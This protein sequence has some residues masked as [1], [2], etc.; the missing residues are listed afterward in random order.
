MQCLTLLL[1]SLVQSHKHQVPFF[2]LS[3]LISL[4]I[5]HLLLN[6]IQTKTNHFLVT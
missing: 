4:L 2:I 3:L 5:S 1:R 6:Y